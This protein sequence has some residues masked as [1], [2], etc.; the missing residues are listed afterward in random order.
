MG[1]IRRVE[2]RP[3][4]SW[5]RRR[6]HHAAEAR[7]GPPVDGWRRGAGRG[8][9][10]GCGSRR[11]GRDRPCPGPHGRRRGRPGRCVGGRS[12]AEEVAADNGGE[13]VGFVRQGSEVEV[14]VRVSD[15]EAVARAAAGLVSPGGD[16]EA[17]VPTLGPMSLDPRTDTVPPQGAGDASVG[18]RQGPPTAQISAP[19][20]GPVAPSPSGAPPAASAPAPVE[21]RAAA[22]TAAPPARA[23]GRTRSR[24]E[25]RQVQRI[26]T[27][28]DPWSVLK[29]SLLLA[30]SL[31]LILVVAGVVLWRVAVATGT[32]GK[33][34]NFVAQLLA[35][36][37]FVIDGMQ[38]LRGLGHRRVGVGGDRCG[39]GRH[40]LRAVQPD[41]RAH[42]RY[43][44]HRDRA[45][46]GSS[47]RPSRATTLT[48]RRQ[49][50]GPPPTDP[51]SCP[52][53]H[54]AI[55]QLVRAH[56]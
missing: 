6:G 43:P 23:A 53:P 19:V 36:D 32:I 8:A 27:R 39:P 3:P 33:F 2:D 12:E 29:V 1:P 5:D 52:L 18:S 54:G 14:T 26:L 48:A 17:T 21:P 49:P 4:S 45:R 41:L 37:S 44:G 10:P 31:W 13:L 47:S 35:E 16:R 38:I 15:M 25:A 40:V 22:A 20:V 46:D 30:L 9:G 50:F 34:E 11:G 55:A 42:R 7:P 28:I 51:L 56:P 24:I